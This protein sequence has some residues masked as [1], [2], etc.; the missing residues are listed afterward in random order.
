VILYVPER[1]DTFTLQL[2]HTARKAAL[3]V[4]NVKYFWLLTLYSHI[5]NS[6]TKKSIININNFKEAFQ[7]A[8]EYTL[9]HF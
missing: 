6:F 2:G 1:N 3:S 9:L 7:H 5:T 8:A 4:N